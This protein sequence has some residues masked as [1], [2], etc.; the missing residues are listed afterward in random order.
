MSFWA[1]AQSVC[2][3][4]QL[5]Q[6][7]DRVVYQHL[8]KFHIC[9][10]S[11]FTSFISCS[12]WPHV[13]VHV[14][15]VSVYRKFQPFVY[16]NTCCWHWW[17]ESGKILWP[18]CNTCKILHTCFTRFIWIFPLNRKS[19]DVYS[20]SNWPWMYCAQDNMH[21]RTFTKVIHIILLWTLDSLSWKKFCLSLAIDVKS[22]CQYRLIWMLTCESIT[23]MLMQLLIFCWKPFW[24]YSIL[25]A[26]DHVFH[27]LS[28]NPVI[29][30]FHVKFYFQ[31]SNLLPCIWLMLLWY[32]PVVWNVQSR[33][34]STCLLAF[35]W[36][37]NLGGCLILTSCYLLIFFFD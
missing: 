30:Y 23:L 21:V 32:V 5:N 4:L 20:S 17:Q 36:G 19:Q 25:K 16:W 24:S 12:S 9:W 28:L 15:N 6:L 22:W 34:W 33:S 8:I 7:T 37:T 1:T 26:H 10:F 11:V 18:S 14:L 2:K 3:Y 13:K 29:K 27:L 31:F 35:T